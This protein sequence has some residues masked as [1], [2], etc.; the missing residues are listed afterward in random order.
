MQGAVATNRHVAHIDHRAGSQ[1][2]FCQAEETLQHLWLRCPR[3][4]PLFS[5]LKQWVGGLGHSFEDELFILLFYS[6]ALRRNICLVN[7]LL[8]Q[9]KMSIWLTRR[10]KIKETGSVDVDLMFRGLV[11]TRLRMEFAYYKMVA[12][13][14]EFISIG[15][16]EMFYVV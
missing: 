10:N 3:L 4:T 13:L 6:A 1:C 8:G 14:N 16:V 12:D 7:F 5:L 15:E 11:A 2:E 9:A